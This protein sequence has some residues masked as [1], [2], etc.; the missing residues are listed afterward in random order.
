MIV[1]VM[2]KRRRSVESCVVVVAVV[3]CWVWHWWCCGRGTEAVVHEVV[4]VVV[5]VGEGV[6]HH[7]RLKVRA[8]CVLPFAFVRV[9]VA[10]EGLRG[11]KVAAAVVALEPSAALA[12]GFG[13]SGGSGSGSVVPFQGV[14][15]ECGE[16]VVVVVM[17]VVCCGL[18][19]FAVVGRDG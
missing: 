2:R 13:D 15:V 10:A 1:V 6:I 18:F 5:R 7:G 11:G 14:E 8:F 16:V 19:G 12:V 17:V 9:L 4:H 3:P